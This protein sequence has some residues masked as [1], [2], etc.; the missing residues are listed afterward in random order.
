M[1]AITEILDYANNHGVWPVLFL[2]LLL[3]GLPWILKRDKAQN[4]KVEKLYLERLDDMKNG[5]K[6]TQ[7]MAL[8][9]NDSVV[10][11]DKT[12]ENMTP[13]LEKVDS[14]LDAITRTV[15]NMA[16]MQA[17][18]QGDLQLD[19]SQNVILR[20]R[21]ERTNDLLSKVKD[22]LDA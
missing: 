11:F 7:E 2:G 5:Q 18:M 6:I 3:F 16:D 21:L 1:E 14:S 19:K 8:A 4:D 10:K 20:E 9:F 15:T 22:R 17:R 12:I 13:R